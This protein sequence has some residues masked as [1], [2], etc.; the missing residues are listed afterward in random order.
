M[1]LQLMRYLV[2]LT[3]FMG[4]LF[5]SIGCNQQGAATNKLNDQKIGK[6]I[7]LKIAGMTCAACPKAVQISLEKVNHV[8]QAEVDYDTAIAKVYI[9]KNKSIDVDTLIKAVEKIGYKA[10]LTS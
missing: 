5:I 7:K 6:V 4:I 8:V 1:K 10:K 9:E 3:A 2:V